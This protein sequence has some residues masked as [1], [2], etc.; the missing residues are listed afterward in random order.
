MW[1]LAQQTVLPVAAPEAAWGLAHVPAGQT[2]GPHLT[3]YHSSKDRLLPT[4]TRGPFPNSPHPPPATPPTMESSAAQG[5]S[6]ARV[7][8]LVP[9]AIC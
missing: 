2:M 6:E 7:G 9:P 1:A 5:L 8:L 3:S 4:G